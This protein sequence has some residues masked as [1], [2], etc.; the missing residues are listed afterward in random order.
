MGI[1][2]SHRLYESTKPSFRYVKPNLDKMDEIEV[3]TV[4]QKN[5]SDQYLADETKATRFTENPIEKILSVQNEAQKWDMLKRKFFYS[6]KNKLAGKIGIYQT[7]VEGETLRLVSFKLYMDHIRAYDIQKL[8]PHIKKIDDPIK[9]NALIYYEIPVYSSVFQPT[10]IPI[11][12]QKGE[13]LISLNYRISHDVTKWVE[14]YKNNM[15]YLKNPHKLKEG[16]V[17]YYDAEWNLSSDPAG[18]TII[19]EV[20][21]SSSDLE[22]YF[23]MQANLLQGEGSLAGVQGDDFEEF[24]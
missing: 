20:I 24:K 17:L 1:S 14:L 5:W 10:G 13:G 11:R 3:L 8:N 19:P 18:R 22:Y 7:A 4:N 9:R 16:D 2:C 21:Y 23:L 15:I 6:F 12:A